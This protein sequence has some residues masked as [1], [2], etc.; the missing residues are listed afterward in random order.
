MRGKFFLFLY[1]HIRRSH[2]SVCEDI[3]F[4]D[5]GGERVLGGRY[6]TACIQ[7]LRLLFFS[8][9]YIYA[10]IAMKILCEG[11]EAQ[12]G[13][14]Y[15]LDLFFSLCSLHVL[16]HV[17]VS[18]SFLGFGCSLWVIEPPR[19]VTALIFILLSVYGRDLMNRFCQT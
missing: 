4:A 19:N 13:Q 10:L 3:V 2:G 7:A 15:I 8:L 17:R 18:L 9:E 1:L 11:P 14:K 5:T 12:R 16:T 6:H